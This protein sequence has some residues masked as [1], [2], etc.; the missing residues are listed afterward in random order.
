[1]QAAIR[2]I[3]RQ[4]PVRAAYLFG[5]HAEGAA[6]RF[7]DVDIAAFVE[8]AGQWDLK[9]RVRVTVEVQK[10]FGDDVELHFFAAELLQNAPAASFAAYVQTHGVR[11]D[12]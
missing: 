9:R 10:Q 1:M 3:E 8:G 2:V 4:A 7:G 6:D 12:L 5:S 11:I